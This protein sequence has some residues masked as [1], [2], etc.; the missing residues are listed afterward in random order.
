[1]LRLLKGTAAAVFFIVVLSM[2]SGA[3]SNKRL[4]TSSFDAPVEN[5]S[6]QRIPAKLMEDSNVKQKQK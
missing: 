2:L 4:P 1:M 3:Q 5:V 6:F